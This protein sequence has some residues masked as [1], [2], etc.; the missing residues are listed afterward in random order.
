[1]NQKVKHYTC[2]RTNEQK[3]SKERKKFNNRIRRK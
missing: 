3:K 1:M 2:K